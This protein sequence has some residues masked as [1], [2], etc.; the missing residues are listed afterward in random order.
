MQYSKNVFPN[1][2]GIKPGGNNG[3]G[4]WSTSSNGW[5]WQLCSTEYTK[6][7]EGR[8]HEYMKRLKSWWILHRRIPHWLQMADRCIQPQQLCRPCVVVTGSISLSSCSC[9]AD[10]KEFLFESNSYW[11]GEIWAD[12]CGIPEPKAKFVYNYIFMEKQK[13]EKL[14]ES[15][16]PIGP[17]DGCCESF[18]RVQRQL[19]AQL[20]D[21]PSKYK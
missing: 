2:I 10:G 17:I 6:K 9:I 3:Y 7:L 13:S 21:L 20:I 15:K 16:I 19:V 12:A 1:I 4:C 18:L 5:M 11:G 14:T 8:R